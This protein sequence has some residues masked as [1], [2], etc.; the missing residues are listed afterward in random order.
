MPYQR[1]RPRTFSRVSSAGSSLY[2]VRTAV[3]GV[4][5]TQ[6]A[7]FQGL[8]LTSLQADFSQVTKDARIMAINGTVGA[9]ETATP[10]ATVQ[11][12]FC[13]GIVNANI[14]LTAAQT[15]PIPVAAG[16][17]LPWLWRADWFQPYTAAPANPWEVTETNR[18]LN[19]RKRKGTPLRHLRSL[20]ETLM[21]CA[22]VTDGGGGNWTLQYALNI[23][24]K[25]P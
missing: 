8:A 4:V 17:T 24:V 25:I 12:R 2:W 14:L 22:G 16:S 19:L 21:L 11:G 20:D 1:S 6:A 18:R 13:A 9:V 5:V 15:N 3:T 7:P 23:L 10:A